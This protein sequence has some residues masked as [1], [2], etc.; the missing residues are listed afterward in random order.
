MLHCTQ[1][2]VAKSTWKYSFADKL[3]EQ[4]R[5][6]ATTYMES[7]GCYLD[8]RVKGQRNTEQKFMTGSTV[9]DYVVGSMR[10]AKSK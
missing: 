7:I 1:L 8:L 10:D 6:K 4:G 3:D 5:E 2:N 9:D